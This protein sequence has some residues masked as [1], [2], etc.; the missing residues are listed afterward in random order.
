MKDINKTEVIFRR[1]SDGQIL[2]VFPYDISTHEGE[3]T[4]YAH[5][6]QHSQADYNY[7]VMNCKPAKESEYTPLFQELESIGYNLKTI[8][9]R[10]YKKYLKALYEI[11][12][13]K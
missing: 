7:C 9:R 12:T 2:A 1:E 13:K 4:V 3:I 8:K 11:Q 6:G 5:L 10:N